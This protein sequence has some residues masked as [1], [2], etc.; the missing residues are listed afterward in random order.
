MIIYADLMV[1][2]DENI[3]IKLRQ[4]VNLTAAV[5]VGGSF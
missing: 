5:T 1:T 2:K 3:K 4:A